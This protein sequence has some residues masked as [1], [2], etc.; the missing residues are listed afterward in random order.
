MAEFCRRNHIRKLSLFGSVLT[1]R[2][3][4]EGDIDVRVD[5][6]PDHVPGLLDVAR[7]EREPSNSSPEKWT[8]APP[9]TSAATFANKF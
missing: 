6:D 5:F 3:R 8:F 4:A 9:K 1:P 7:M 2:F